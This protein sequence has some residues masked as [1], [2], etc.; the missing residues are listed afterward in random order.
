MS[1]RMIEHDDQ[2]G[3]VPWTLSHCIICGGGSSYSQ[4]F[5]GVQLHSVTFIEAA[6]SFWHVPVTCF[7]VNTSIVSK[8]TQDTYAFFFLLSLA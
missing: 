7:V 2:N 3:F 8:G 6:F 4:P 1:K 5:T